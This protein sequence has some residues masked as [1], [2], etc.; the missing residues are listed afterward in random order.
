MKVLLQ[1]FLSI[2]VLVVGTVVGIYVE[3]YNQEESGKIR[4][5]DYKIN[6]SSLLNKPVIQ[7]KTLD[8]LLD[9][10]P[11]KKLSQLEISIY[12]NSDRDYEN[13][14]LFLELTPEEGESFSLVATEAV[15]AGSIPETIEAVNVQPS[16]VV[17]SYRTGYTIKTV[18]RTSDRESP[19]F[20][21]TFLI[22]G[23]LPNKL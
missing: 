14:P 12:N 22:T 17:G 4:Y 15:G 7:G 5:L 2:A 1:F 19:E 20:F 8:V 21:A 18:N 6:T 3:K 16:K 10:K 13:V 11:I 9:G 23:D